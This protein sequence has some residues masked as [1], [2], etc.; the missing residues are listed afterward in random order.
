MVHEVLA[1]LPE[2][3]RLGLT[4]ERFDSGAAAEFPYL[5]ACP[6]RTSPGV[7]CAP[8]GANRVDVGK[9]IG[10][11][12]CRR[13]LPFPPGTPYPVCRIEVDEGVAD[14]REAA[15]EISRELLR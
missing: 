7:L 6:Q 9:S 12:H 11:Q 14:R 1:L 5:P 3:L 2:H 13:R 4:G 8:G 10:R 15:S